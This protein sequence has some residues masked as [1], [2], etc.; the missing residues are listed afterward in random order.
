MKMRMKESIL[1]ASRFSSSSLHTKKMREVNE[2]REKSF[3]C[4]H[5]HRGLG[6]GRKEAEMEDGNGRKFL[7]FFVFIIDGNLS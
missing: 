1:Y 2:K 6:N 7:Y 3:L 4:L 5:P